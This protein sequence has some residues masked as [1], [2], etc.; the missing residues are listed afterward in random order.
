MCDFSI[1]LIL[2]E[3]FG[4]KIWILIKTRRNREW[5]ILHALLERRILCFN[6]YKNRGLKVKLWWVGAPERNKSPFFVIFILWQGSFF[7]ICVLYQ[8]M[9]YQI[10]F[11]FMFTF[12]Y[13]KRFS[14]TLLL[15][16][17]KFVKYP[18]VYL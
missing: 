13:H 4:T 15:L 7:N 14:H 5:K 12:R 3:F 17:F 8:F 1:N 2:E 6:S 18:S 11:L 16:V 10:N 9:V